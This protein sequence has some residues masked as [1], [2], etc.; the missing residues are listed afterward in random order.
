ML[1]NQEEYNKTSRDAY[2][3]GSESSSHEDVKDL[4][5]ITTSAFQELWYVILYIVC[6]FFFLIVNGKDYKFQATKWLEMLKKKQFK[7]AVLEI[8]DEAVVKGIKL[9]E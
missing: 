2:I 6:M 9:E 4:Y 8:M 7:E 1:M 3:F 5:A